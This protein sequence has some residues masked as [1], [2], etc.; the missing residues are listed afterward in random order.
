MSYYPDPYDPYD[1]RL[2][3]PPPP[4]LASH[5]GIR[6][7]YPYPQPSFLNRRLGPQY[8]LPP[9]IRPSPLSQHPSSVGRQGVRFED[10]QDRQDSSVDRRRGI[11]ERETT[12]RRQKSSRHRSRSPPPTAKPTRK[13]NA[14]RTYGSDSES[15]G[16]DTGSDSE[17]D[18]S[19]DGNN[20]R[21]RN[22][23]SRNRQ[24]EAPRSSSRLPDRSKQG[25]ESKIP[26]KHRSDRS[27]RSDRSN[28]TTQIV[29]PKPPK[30]RKSK[31]VLYKSIAKTTDDGP[32]SNDA[33]NDGETTAF[34]KE[35]RFWQC[36]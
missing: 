28:R 7:P 32:I 20:V 21:V 16:S 2:R 18:D 11:S 24:E 3:R 34:F 30:P 12:S 31:P 23:L 19:R 13:S 25:K 14:R 4:Y 10:R 17:S 33:Q 22:D 26:S 5:P 8:R 6:P 1:P 15:E 29:A 9:S 36:R 35:G 27:D